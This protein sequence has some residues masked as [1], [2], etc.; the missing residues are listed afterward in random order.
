MAVL[1]WPHRPD[2][3]Q[4]PADNGL[5]PRPATL[6]VWVALWVG[7]AALEGS[8][9]N[10]SP[11]YAPEAMKNAALAGPGWLHAAGQ[12]VGGLIGPHGALFAACAGTVQAAVGLA[13]LSARIRRAAL[14]AG[15]AL[16]LFYAVV[17]QAFGGIFSNGVLGIM[18]SG[19][20]DP[21]TGP[22]VVL[23]ALALW[24]RNG[25]AVPAAAL[26]AA[27]VPAAAAVTAA[28]ADPASSR[29]PQ[30]LG[31]FTSLMARHRQGRAADRMR[32]PMSRRPAADW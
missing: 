16:A 15:C 18:S 10:R 25:A 13:I 7:T 32:P 22:V 8:Y 29:R 31:S 14:V 27:A 28:D 19:A 17:G 9:L 6:L 1:L 12:A 11:T 5:L 24:P 2:E 20:T 26:P 4:A 23:L 3:G 30:P 21:G